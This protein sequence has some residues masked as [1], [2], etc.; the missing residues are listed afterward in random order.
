MTTPS[1]TSAPDWTD[2]WDA[3][4]DFTRIGVGL[5]FGLGVMAFVVLC[6]M[7]GPMIRSACLGLLQLAW[8]PLFTYQSVATG[9]LACL[10]AAVLAVGIAHARRT[11]R[12]FAS[13]RPK[14]SGKP[15]VGSGPFWT[16]WA[17]ML[18]STAVGV[19]CGLFQ[20]SRY[21]DSMGALIFAIVLGG[22]V[23]WVLLGVLCVM[24]Y[25]ESR[26]DPTSTAWF[27]PWV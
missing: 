10:Y 17:V 8:L 22:F 26:I 3:M 1:P 4:S 6:S 19:L 11:A 14:V 5:A 12:A 7:A 27:G 23:P 13:R 25:G 2:R 20:V 18:V 21:Q 24:Y 15:P 9:Y 16:W